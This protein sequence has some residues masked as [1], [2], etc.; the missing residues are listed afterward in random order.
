M[1]LIRY[2]RQSGGFSRAVD[3]IQE[4][5][6]SIITDILYHVDGNFTTRLYGLTGEFMMNFPYQL[7]PLSFLIL[8]W[9]VN[10]VDSF[11]REKKKDDIKLFIYP[12]LVNL[13]FLVLMADSDNVMYFLIKNGFFPFLFILTLVKIHEKR[14]QSV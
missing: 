6:E 7:Y 14:R 2:Q 8:A 10:K 4:L 11:W 3:M 5:S 12:M 13:C 1:D 9:L